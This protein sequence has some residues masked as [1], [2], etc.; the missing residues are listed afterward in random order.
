MEEAARAEEITQY[1]SIE[2][3]NLRMRDMRQ[4]TCREKERHKEVSLLANATV[5][6]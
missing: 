4:N 5:T 3:K 6:K 1:E 2:R